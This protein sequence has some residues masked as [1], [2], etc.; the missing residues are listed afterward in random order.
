MARDKA[1][2]RS[3]AG[4][5]LDPIGSARGRG[6]SVEAICRE[7]VA[8][9]VDGGACDIEHRLGSPV[10]KGRGLGEKGGLGRASEQQARESLARGNDAL[11][12]AVESRAARQPRR[13]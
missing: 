7:L 2:A 9:V 4:G 10:F 3:E 1:E 11:V 12:E 8:V 5:H 6:A 13:R